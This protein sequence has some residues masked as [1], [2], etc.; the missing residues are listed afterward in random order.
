M[1]SMLAAL[2]DVDLEAQQTSEFRSEKTAS[3]KKVTYK[4]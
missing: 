2:D 4:R 3:L 1:L